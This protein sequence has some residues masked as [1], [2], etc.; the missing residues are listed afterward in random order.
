MEELFEKLQ[1]PPD[2]HKGQN[3][4]VLVIGGSRKYAGAP[5]LTAQA[6]LR[7]G[8][9]LV[10]ILTAKEAKP[11]VQC[12]SENL[13]VESYGERF[14]ESSL[15]KA[16]DLEKWADTTVIG[17]G[18]SDFDEKALKG[19]GEK[20]SDVVI[21]AEAIKPLIQESGRIFTP[22]SGEAQVMRDE[23]GSEK[24]FASETGNTVLLKG[25]VDKIFS[26]DEVFRNETGSLGMTVGGTGDVLAGIVASF[27]AQG[28]DKT[29]ASRLGA[30]VNGEAGEKAFEKHG[31]G[32]LATDVIKNLAKVIS[33]LG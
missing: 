6:A 11:V 7:A 17:P 30:Y 1:R 13:I 15:K 9:D 10:K 16:L 22:H 31:N 21:D 23:Y 3:G 33:G 27:R 12:F 28:L 24:A 19:F 32:L 26:G 2:T 14:N 5:A 4:K 25:E 20:A 29:E 18:L 8:A